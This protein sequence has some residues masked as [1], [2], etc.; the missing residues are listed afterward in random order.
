MNN[1]ILCK[2]NQ[3][4]EVLDFGKHPVSHHFLNTRADKEETHPILVGQCGGCGTVQLLSFIPVNKMQPKYDWLTCTEPEAHLDELVKKLSQLPGITEESTICGVSFKEDTTLARLNR[5][6]FHNTWRVDPETELEIEG[7]LGKIETIIETIQE[8]WTP[9]RAEALIE[10]HGQVDIVIARHILEHS[11]KP[12]QFIEACKKM[13][14]PGGYVVFEVP[15]CL[16]A[17]DHFDYTV[18]W[19]DH[20]VYFTPKTFYNCFGFVGLLLVYFE[21]ISYMLED[22]IIGIARLADHSSLV[23]IDQSNLN[24]EVQRINAFVENFDDTVSK[25]KTFL[26]DFK[27][28]GETVALFGSGHMGCAFINYLGLKDY[29]NFVIDDNPNLKSMFMPGSKLPIL[30]SEDLIKK[31]VKLC[32][33]TL[34]ITSEDKVIQKN[35]QFIE[36]GGIFLS[37]FPGSKYNWPLKTNLKLSQLD[38][39]QV[40][41]EVF[42]PEQDNVPVTFE[43]VKVL[44]EKAF[45]NER[46]RNRLC[47][48]KSIAESLHEMLIVHT[49]KNYVRPHMYVKKSKSIHIIEGQLDVILFDNNGK[50]IDVVRMGDYASKK[51][52]YFR[53]DNSQYHSL[54]VDSEIAVFHESTDGPFDP[55][56]TLYASWA[57]DENDVEPVEKY[58]QILKSEKNKYFNIQQ[59]K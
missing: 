50:I 21:K 27:E 28:K 30:P 6:G 32:F 31:K 39:K 53:I 42:F 16:H 46:L 45:K 20:T 2:A 8:R 56:D 44:K 38:V 40:S 22:S 23:N 55:T 5:I 29:I 26:Q 18:I 3:V 43:D 35:H 11:Q 14:K 10:K 34:S 9:E 33:S 25:C 4:R 49:N 37:I 12:L 51:V 58:I 41:K 24:N 36:G 17:L 54:E 52:F 19:E 47:T 48:H 1:C 57:P 13:L 15:D 59:S 7:P